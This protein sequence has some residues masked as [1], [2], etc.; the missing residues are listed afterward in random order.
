MTGAAVVVFGR[1]EATV[2]ATSANGKNVHV[3]GAT[4]EGWT[5]VSNVKAVKP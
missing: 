1:H 5:S 4:Y 2:V 3:V